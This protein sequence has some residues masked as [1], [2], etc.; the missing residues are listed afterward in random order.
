M[1]CEIYSPNSWQNLGL[2]RWLCV[3]ALMLVAAAQAGEFQYTA[4][5]L[6]QPEEAYSVVPF[7]INA[8][9][10]VVGWVAISGEPIRGCLWRAGHT[11]MIILPTPPGENGFYARDISDG[12]IIAGGYESGSAWTFSHG[13]YNF[14]GNLPGTGSAEAK[15]VNEFG[16]AV[17][18][19]DPNA[20]LNFQAFYYDAATDE[21]VQMAPY[22][23]RGSDINDAGQATGYHGTTAFRYTLDGGLEDLG[24]LSFIYSFTV[25]SA[26]NQAGDVV[27]G[28][29][30]VTSDASR[31]FIYTDAEGM[32]EIP[33]IGIINQAW[34]LN[35]LG[36][37]VGS[38][39]QTG[40]ADQGWV[41]S[42]ETGI[43]MLADIIDPSAHLGIISATDINNDGQIIGYGT[44]LIN[45]AA[46]AVRLTPTIPC[47]G[48]A[49]GDGVIDPLDSGFVLARFGCPVGGGDPNCDV[50]DQNDDGSVDPLDVG[51]VLARFGPCDG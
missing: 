16:D 34:G 45:Y 40:F 13:K 15:G 2:A 26:I 29:D 21:I 33:A 31:A 27:G 12:R 50:A 19:A 7:G 28:A 41:W 20:M 18:T 5:V 46:V 47:E 3:S 42:A 10:D 17:G 37:V 49:N 23:S 4:A 24:P 51:F 8:A 1:R 25:G 32:Q 6:E 39:E 9:G 30:D 43:Q 38:S 22:P 44:D 14:L 36:V 35:D 11:D 48:D